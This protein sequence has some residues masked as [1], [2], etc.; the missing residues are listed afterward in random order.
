MYKLHQPF[1]ALRFFP[2]F[3]QQIQV[4]TDGCHQ[5]SSILRQLSFLIQR[6]LCPQL[7]QERQ[8]P[9]Q[10]TSLLCPILCHYS[11][12][13]Q[14]FRL[15]SHILNCTCTPK[16]LHGKFIFT[17]RSEHPEILPLR[18]RQIGHQAAGSRIPVTHLSPLLASPS[19]RRGVLSFQTFPLPSF[20]LF[21]LLFRD[22]LL[23]HTL[24]LTSVVKATQLVFVH[25]SLRLIFTFS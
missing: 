19:K 4:A 12:M 24:F 13:D 1:S 20:F 25:H 5:M 10:Q 18:I 15:K 17:A 2:L 7:R 6:I 22:T 21:T 16:L 9:P 14:S 11:C 8:H 3:Y 23:F